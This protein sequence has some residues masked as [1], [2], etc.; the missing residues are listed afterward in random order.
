MKSWWFGIWVIVEALLVLCSLALWFVATEHTV[1]NI[2]VT[3]FTILLGGILF[4]PRRTGLLVWLSSRHGRNTFIHLSRFAL[5]SAIVGLVCYLAWKFPLQ[6]DFSERALNTLSAQSQRILADLPKDT[7]ITLYARRQ[8]WPR[9]MALLKLYREERKDIILTAVD[10][11]TRPQEA[12]N[13]GVQDTGT[14]VVEAGGKRVS[15]LLQDELTVTNALLKMVRE[16][17]VRVYFTWGHN[18]AGCDVT[19][20]EGISSFCEHLKRQNYQALRLDLQTATDVPVDADVVIIWGA[21]SGFLPQEIQRLQRYLEKGGSLL[22]LYS[23]SFQ[24]DNL[25]ELRALAAMWGIEARNDLVVDSLSSVETQE[26]TIPLVSKYA[27]NHPITRGYTSRTLF[28]LSSSVG[29]TKPLYQGVA[30]TPLTYTSDFP[31]S[32]GEQDL[33]GVT[34]GKANF[35]DGKDIKGPVSIVTVS[36]RLPEAGGAQDTRVGVIGN[37]VFTRN[38]Y[39]NQTANMNLMLNVVGWLSH[40]EGLVTLNR[41]GLSHEPVVLSA[42]HLRFVFLITVIAVPVV[43]FLLALLVFRRRRRL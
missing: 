22:W 30:V 18:E 27:P 41:P 21:T 33:Q 9:A 14:V 43:A 16:R 34:N 31:G 19:G 1:L 4:Y 38:A 28:P 29:V 15:F 23:P 20:P 7:K 26:A 24:Q 25:K 5:Y 11:E 3:V 13:A 35:T 10:P 39:Q 37:D 36:E 40:D 8:E 2:S 42:Q 17:L 6:K 32:W 12:R